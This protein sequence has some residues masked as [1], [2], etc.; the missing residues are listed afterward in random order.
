M[1]VHYYDRYEKPPEENPTVGIL[2]CKKKDDALV[3]FK[4]IVL[5]GYL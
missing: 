1:Y 3:E 5:G 2:L 4:E